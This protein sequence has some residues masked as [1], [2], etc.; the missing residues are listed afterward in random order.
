MMDERAERGEEISSFVDILK[1]DL[2][3]RRDPP[4]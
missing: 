4:G 1:R 3:D 2:P